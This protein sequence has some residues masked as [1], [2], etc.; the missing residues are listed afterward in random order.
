MNT[1]AHLIFGAGFFAK[2]HARSITLAALAG[3]LFPDLSLYVLVAWAMLVQQVPP[4]IIFDDLYFSPEWRQVFAIDNSI[5]LWTLVACAGFWA[6][7]P[8]VFAFAGAALLHLLLD[9]PLH[10]D[11]GRPHFWP[12]SMWVFES[13]V[14]YWDSTRYARL[15]APIEGAACL[16]LVV[17][18]WRRFRSWTARFVFSVLMAAELWVIRQ[19]LL[20]F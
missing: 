1:P 20:F 8:E 2:P 16:A 11:D 4:Q 3:A 15:V 9:L 14:S 5:P 13:P 19:W 17:L 6:K 12:F 10:H 18:L 7:R